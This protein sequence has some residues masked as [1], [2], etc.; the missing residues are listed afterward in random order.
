MA[1]EL[2]KLS[3][4][5]LKELCDISKS[6]EKYD[7]MVNR[8]EEVRK[9]ENER[10]VLLALVRSLSEF[11][12]GRRSSYEEEKSQLLSLVAECNK[13]KDQIQEKATTLLEI[14]RRTSLESTLA[15]VLAATTAAEEESES[16]AHSFLESSIGLDS[17]IKEYLEK[18]KVA[19]LRRIRADRLRQ[20]TN[21][22]WTGI[23]AQSFGALS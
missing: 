13:L 14:S 19:H 12:L 2:T 11:N 7:E 21:E 3:N 23:R 4:E 20:E 18:R 15:V 8:S 6:E 17:F 9:L 10:E 16:I 1:E 22:S 5:E